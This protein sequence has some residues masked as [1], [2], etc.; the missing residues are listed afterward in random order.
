MSIPLVVSVGVVPPAN[1]TLE[2]QGSATV[3]PL[4]NINLNFNQQTFLL[5]NK[6][7]IR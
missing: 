1:L 3:P 7:Q 5:K 4:V 2:G 6:V